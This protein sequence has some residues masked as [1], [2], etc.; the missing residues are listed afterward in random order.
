MRVD[1]MVWGGGYAGCRGG[2]ARGILF[3]LGLIEDGR[4][5]QF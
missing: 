3:F 2:F 5:K 4:S 1:G